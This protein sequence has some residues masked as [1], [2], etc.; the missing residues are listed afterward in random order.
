MHQGRLRS[1]RPFLP[2][3]LKVLNSLFE[4]DIHVKQWMKHRWNVDYLE[5]TLRVHAFIPRV[6][7]RPLGMSLPRTS[8][9]RL[10][11]LRTGVGRFHSSMYKWGLAPSPNCKCVATEQMQI[12][13]YLHVFYIMHHEER[14]VCRF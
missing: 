12:T 3:A 14:K 11:H 10:N 5:S 4:L 9:V 7:S 13:L 2:A 1:R 6:T 8:W